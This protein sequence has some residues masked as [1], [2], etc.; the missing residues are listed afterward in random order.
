DWLALTRS[1]GPRTPW[2]C[3]H[4]ELRHD[5]HGPR[6]GPGDTRHYVSRYYV[7]EL[8][9]GRRA[10]AERDER[11]GLWRWR[12]TPEASATRWVRLHQATLKTPEA[13]R[14]AYE[15]ALDAELA[16]RPAPP[17]PA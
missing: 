17:S 11:N 5:W 4:L 8:C 15:T 1:P 13:V 7:W 12:D 6:G 2:T 9:G 16:Q 14:Q 10:V 3:L